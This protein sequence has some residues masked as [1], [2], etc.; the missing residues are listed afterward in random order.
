MGIELEYYHVHTMYSNLFTS[1]DSPASPQDYAK[2]MAKR[3]CRT[4][5]LT[6]H[7]NRGPIFEQYQLIKKYN[8]DKAIAGAE[9]YFVPDRN[10]Q[11]KD[12]RNFHLVVLA[13][14]QTGFEELNMLCT[15]AN[16]TGFYGKARVDFNLLSQL[17]PN[18]FLVT[19][20]CIGGVIADE[21]GQKYCKRLYDIFGNN[22]Y[23][24]VQHHPQ[25]SQALHNKKV[26]DL[27]LKHHWPLIAGTD[28][29]YVN[30]EDKILREELMLS[31]G[32]TKTY[33][34]E[35]DLYLPAANEIVDMFNQQGVLT[36]SQIYNS[37]QNTLLLRDFDG[38]KFTN[39]RKF[40][41]SRPQ[42][43]EK[44]RKFLYQ[45]MV[46]DGYIEKE[47]MPTKEQAAELRTEMN[48]VLET[49]SED[50]F[51]SH[52]DLIAEAKKRGGVL[53]TT[54]RGSASSFATNYALG[55]STVNRLHTPVKLY[56]DRFVS[57]AKLASG[58]MPD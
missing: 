46:C 36:K 10:P 47:G 55:F 24:E 56:A 9:V 8:I 22:F 14:N 13:K 18:N 33:E 29:H 37:I 21:E 45:K 58:S 30:K 19:T 20:A 11:L 39:E 23:L 53:T 5:C 32:I 6:E 31:G 57:K 44:E 15:E 25:K 41:I 1:N 34:D 17:N 50:Y 35:Y 54:G 28:S 52:V 3:G 27:H 49:N 12:K 51:I 42:L 2:V 40:P 4:F 16:L 48:T 38:C 7:G 26:I 43:S